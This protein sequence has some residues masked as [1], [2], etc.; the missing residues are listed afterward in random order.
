MAP[1]NLPKDI[2]DLL[3]GQFRGMVNWYKNRGS[4]SA[5]AFVVVLVQP[6]KE[7]FGF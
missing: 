1:A 7:I 4:A 3:A 6:N 2:M 5:L